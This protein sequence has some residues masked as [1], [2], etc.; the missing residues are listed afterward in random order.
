M[1]VTVKAAKDGTSACGMVLSFG[2]GS[3]QKIKINVEG[4]KLPL[5]V[6]HVYK[7]AGKYTV[8]AKGQ[9]I[10]THHSCKDSATAVIRIIAVKQKPKASTSK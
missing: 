4:A 7:K 9:K 10:T 3:D 2:D 1:Q 6:E 5:S 8:Q